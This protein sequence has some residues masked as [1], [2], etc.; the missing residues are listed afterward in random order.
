MK[1]PSLQKWLLLALA[2]LALSS[3]GLRGKLVRPMPLWG[4][5]PRDGPS[6]PRNI[7]DA[8]DK[9]TADKAA[10]DAQRKKEA[11]ELR[12]ATA[13]GSAPPPATPTP[14]TPPPQ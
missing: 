11:D 13:P 4:D 9:A 12:A 6:D 3:C 8:A 2:A 5:P 10:A 1:P 7:K 14:A